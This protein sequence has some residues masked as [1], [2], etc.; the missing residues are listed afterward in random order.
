MRWSFKTVSKHTRPRLDEKTPS[1]QTETL[2]IKR[3][4]QARNFD[5]LETVQE[6]AEAMILSEKWVWIFH[7]GH[8][9]IIYYYLL[10]I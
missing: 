10:I 9:H 2:K 3:V 1:A 4:T 8:N 6:A 7:N 5:A